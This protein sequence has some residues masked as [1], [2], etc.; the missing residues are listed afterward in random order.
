MLFSFTIELDNKS[1]GVC[2][3]NKGKDEEN[4]N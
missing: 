2:P 4:E 1:R 3:E